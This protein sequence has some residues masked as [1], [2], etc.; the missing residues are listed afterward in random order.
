M[1]ND[2]GKTGWRFGIRFGPG[3]LALE[4]WMTSMRSGICLIGLFDGLII[5]YV[6]LERQD[7]LALALRPNDLVES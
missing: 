1:R 5:R 3:C 6:A 4:G 7:L 2:P